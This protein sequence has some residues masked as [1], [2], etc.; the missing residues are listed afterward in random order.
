MALRVASVYR[1]VSTAAI[2]V[3]TGIVHVH[4]MARDRCELWLLQKTEVINT[5]G[6]V[7]NNVW[8]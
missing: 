7:D 4:S 8:G 6:I 1:I 5:K 3:V 2:L